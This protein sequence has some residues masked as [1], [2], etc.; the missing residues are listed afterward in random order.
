MT[1]DEARYQARHSMF[2]DRGGYGK[3]M[4]D[5][6]GKRPATDMHEL[7][8]RG[9]TMGNP[10]ARSA[11]FAPELCALLCPACHQQAHN[12]DVR[13]ELFR[14]NMERY[15]G[16]AV[17]EAANAFYR[18]TRSEPTIILPFNILPFDLESKTDE[19]ASQEAAP[20]RPA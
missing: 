19:T 1:F 15:G 20:R 16:G 8:N 18:A 14:R 5:L 6:C 11:S 7:I 10:E 2:V 3:A 4:C 12:P 9:R 17:I 13:D